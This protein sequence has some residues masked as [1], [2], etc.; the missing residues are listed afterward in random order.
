MNSIKEFFKKIFFNPYVKTVLLGLAIVL[1]LMLV[2]MISLR[3]T[4]KHNNSFPV[5]DFRGMNSAE[6]TKAAKHAGL[7]IEVADSVYIMNRIAGSV[8]DQTPAPNT[9]V[10]DNRRIFLIINALNP[11]KVRM[12]NVVGYTLRQAK[13]ILE[14]EGLEIGSLSFKADLGI[15]NVLMQKDEDNEDLPEG[16]M[17]PKGS[18]VKLVLGRGMYGERTS[19]PL[20]IGLK[21]NDA[22]NQ[23]IE[24]S[25]NIGKI[26]FDE[27]INNY[28]DSLD[29]RVYSQY[30]AYSVPNSIAFG[31][32]V[33]IWLT[34]NQAR[35]PVIE[36]DSLINEFKFQQEAIEE[37]ILD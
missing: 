3:I 25:L 22:K 26:R 12:P 11:I 13:A 15:N 33:N 24:A 2:L 1:V 4:T 32:T 23:I 6:F 28:K 5:P 37:E 17:I 21:L 10:K 35:I 14:Q 27:T 18:K 20:L 30:P 7:R 36:K 8:I 9:H 29:A 16:T 34:L 31:N 19:L